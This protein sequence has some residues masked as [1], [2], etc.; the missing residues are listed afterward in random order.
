MEQRRETWDSFWAQALRIDFFSGQWEAYRKAADARAEW[1]ESAFSLDRN[2]PVLS[3]ACG[4]G[5]IELALAR[6]GFRVTG[7]DICPTFIYYAREKAAEENLS[8]TF[9]VADLRA[10]AASGSMPLPGGNGAV[11]CFD[12]LG[13]LS[14]EDEE[15]LAVRMVRALAVGGV[16]L[17]DCPKREEQCSSRTW[18]K[19]GAGHLL[20]DTRWDKANSMLS[21]DPL[22]IGEDGAQT[23][24][25]DPYDPARAGRTGVQRYIYGPEELARIVRG[26]GLGAETAAHQ[27][28]GY[29]LVV[30]RQGGA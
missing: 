11:C 7:I 9:L 18:W 22:F 2:R 26:A 27:R 1:I 13:L 24:L 19:Q 17:V 14:S 25:D 23:L 21:L 5:G 6:R 12:T 10:S 8:A 30:G 20:L 29:T 4:E 3:L 15:A 16:L 28:K